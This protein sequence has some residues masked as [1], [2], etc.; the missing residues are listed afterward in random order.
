MAKIFLSELYINLFRTSATLIFL[1]L[2]YLIIHFIINHKVDGSKN[3]NR[4]KLRTFY[5]LC[6]IFLIF[7]TKIWIDGFTHLF[8][9]LGLV[10]AALVVTNKETIMNLTGWLIIIWRSLF[11]EDDFI[12]I[13]HYKGYVRQIGIFYFMLS[14]MSS[15]TDNAISGRI[16]RIPNSMVITNPITNHSQNSYLIKVT[17]TA[18]I[19]P[20]CDLNHAKEIILKA[21]EDVLHAYCAHKHEY[22][23]E[24]IQRKNKHLTDLSILRP[25]IYAK[26]KFDKPAGIQLIAHY[27]CYTKDQEN[28]EKL[29]WEKIFDVFAHDKKS[30]L[31]F[32]G[33]N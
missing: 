20:I 9:V 14:D 1:V 31:M 22:S 28:L 27:F 25:I 3:R 17:L 21:I 7:M 30:K 8:A 19:T 15:V 32:E 2:L 29:I 18:L 24:F 16:I 33:F 5:I 11:S 13:Q 10:G 26:P 6:F 4:L 23:T 12:E